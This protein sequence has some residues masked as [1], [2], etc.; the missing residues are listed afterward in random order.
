MK[1]QVVCL[2]N[3]YV[4]GKR[5]EECVGRGAWVSNLR[6]S[7]PI[8]F[9]LLLLQRAQRS[10]RLP[11][12]LRMNQWV[13]P[14]VNNWFVLETTTKSNLLDTRWRMVSKRYPEEKNISTWFWS[15]LS[16]SL[17]KPSQSGSQNK[18]IFNVC[19][20]L[21]EKMSFLFC[22]SILYSQ[23][24]VI[25]FT[26]PLSTIRESRGKPFKVRYSRWLI[27]PSGCASGLFLKVA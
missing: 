16:P 24:N 10:G 2:R 15:L 26:T 1:D 7:L 3:T 8:S 13:G 23:Q 20:N 12:L 9:H 25:I 18:F 21:S 6:L 19:I 14:W 17:D 4:G 5:G 22:D 11:L 27:V